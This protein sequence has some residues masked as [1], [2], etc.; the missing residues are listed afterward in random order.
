DPTVILNNRIVTVKK[1]LAKP[2]TLTRSLYGDQ[3]QG[4]KA[5]LI[6]A[7]QPD[8]FTDPTPDY[9]ALLDSRNYKSTVYSAPTVEQIKQISGSSVV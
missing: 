6:F 2:L 1:N 7:L 4:T 3:P 5:S 9:K 8:I